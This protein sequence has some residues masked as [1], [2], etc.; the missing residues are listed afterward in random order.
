MPLPKLYLRDLFWLVVVVAISAAWRRDHQQ[1]SRSPEV[2]YRDLLS[3]VPALRVSLGPYI[4]APA[5][6]E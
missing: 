3:S 4:D 5:G 6:K 1:L 2:V